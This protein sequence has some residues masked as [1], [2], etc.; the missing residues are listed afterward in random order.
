[1]SLHNDDPSQDRYLTPAQPV[2]RQPADFLT[3][4]QAAAFLLVSKSYLDKL[5][6][7]KDSN[8]Q[9]PA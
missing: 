9:P 2:S 8:L 1:M 4:K 5:R 7:R 3:P 6:S